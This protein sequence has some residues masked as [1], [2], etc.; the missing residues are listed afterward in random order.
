[1]RTTA[2]WVAG[3]QTE[4]LG[5]ME[6]VTGVP[7]ATLDEMGRLSLGE[8]LRVAQIQPIINAAAKYGFLPRAFPASDMIAIVN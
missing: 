7:R 2:R 6:T 3:H 5:V 1:M 8:T 4:M